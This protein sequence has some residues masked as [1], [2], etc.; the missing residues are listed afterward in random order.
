MVYLGG[1]CCETEISAKACLHIA[2][3]TGVDEFLI[4]PGL[5]AGTGYVIANNEMQRVLA[6]TKLN[7]PPK[8]AAKR[9]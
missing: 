7:Y 8:S 2:L 9:R 5:G 3:A 6:L 4:K 1:S